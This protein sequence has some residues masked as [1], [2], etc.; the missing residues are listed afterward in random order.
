MCFAAGMLEANTPVSRIDPFEASMKAISPARKAP[1]PIM[2]SRIEIGLISSF[3]VQ[4]RL[5]PSRAAQASGKP[6][7]KPTHHVATIPQPKPSNV[8]D[9]VLKIGGWPMV[10][11]STQIR[12]VI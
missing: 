3:V 12:A 11:Y 8:G 7:I 9:S 10:K 4:G 6:N 2:L 1:I 5:E